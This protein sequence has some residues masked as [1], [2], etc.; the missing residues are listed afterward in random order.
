MPKHL[1]YMHAI[2]AIYTYICKIDTI[3]TY[4]YTT[5]TIYTHINNIYIYNIQTQEILT[6]IENIQDIQPHVQKYKIYKHMYKYTYTSL[7]YFLSK[8][9]QNRD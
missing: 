9:N 8:K 6:H 7:K 5:C 4:T 1:Q 3:Y 2:Y